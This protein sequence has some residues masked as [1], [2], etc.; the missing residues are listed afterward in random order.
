MCLFNDRFLKEFRQDMKFKN[1]NRLRQLF[2]DDELWKEGK[3]FKEEEIKGKLTCMCFFFLWFFIIMHT[4]FFI[5][6]IVLPS[7]EA[8]EE[9]Y[10]KQKEKTVCTLQRTS[11]FPVIFDD[12]GF[13]GDRWTKKRIDT[14]LY[15]WSKFFVVVKMKYAHTHLL[16]FL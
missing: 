12:L 6:R 7:F 16:I 13:D 1:K 8:A 3:F 4:L 10:C 5:V 11:K 2:N 15:H 9:Y 14:G